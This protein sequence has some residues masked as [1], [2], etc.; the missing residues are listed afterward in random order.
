MSH[1]EKA[2]NFIKMNLAET[3]FY[4]N[5][6]MKKHTSFKTGG[7]AD[8]LVEPGD[9]LELQNL[10]K[11]I[12]KENIP[13]IIIGLGSNTI[14]SDHGIREVVIKISKSLSKCT[15]ENETLEAEAGALLTDVSKEAQENGLIGFEFACGIPGTIGGAV[16]MNAG[17][18]DGEIKNIL[19]EILVL[20]SDGE[21]LTRKIYEL[22]LGYRTSIMQTN[23]DIILKAKFH[24]NKGDKEEIKN[25]MDEL[26]RKREQSQPIEFPS[27]GSIFKRPVGHFTGKLIQEANLKGYQIGGAQVSMKHAGFIINADNAATSDILKLIKHIQCEVKSRYDVDLETEVR[28]IGEFE[29][30]ISRDSA[31]PA[32]LGSED[33]R[34]R[35]IRL[36]DGIK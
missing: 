29:S 2:V 12:L 16:F 34:P 32:K 31:K 26:N 17:A 24:L 20:T 15:L 22:E 36:Q 6:D 23:G 3:V 30:D 1:L 19:E 8:L 28:F 14:V 13:Y 25:K 5:E 35:L 7:R 27:A 33:F 21:F 18:F 11:Y 4:L 9:I 10:I